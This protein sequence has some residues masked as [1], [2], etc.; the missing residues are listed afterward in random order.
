MSEIIV[1]LIVAAIVGLAIYKAKRPSVPPTG[2]APESD[3]PV[4][5]YR[6]IDRR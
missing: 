4:K 3:E 2:V 1:F 6:P 5:P